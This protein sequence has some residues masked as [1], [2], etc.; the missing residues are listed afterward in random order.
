MPPVWRA[1]SQLKS[2]VRTLPMCRKPVGAG[3]N[4]TRTWVIVASLRAG[5]RRTQGWTANSSQRSGTP[6]SSCSP[7]ID[8]AQARTG[9]EVADRARHEHLARPGL[10]T[11]PEPRCA[12]RARRDRRRAA[13][14]HRCGCRP[15]PRTP[16]RAAASTIA[17]ARAHR[18]RRAVERR[19][20]AV[21]RR[22]DL[23]PAVAA[24]LGA[25]DRVVRVELAPARPRRPARPR[26][27]RVDDVGEE[28][29]RRAPGPR[30]RA[31]AR[32][33]TPRPRRAPRR[34]SPSTARGRHPARARAARPG[35]LDAR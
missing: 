28:H 25:H 17:I 24:E 27:G 11:R 32:S 10:R 3:E 31:G 2:A 29:R 1:C 26:A 5:P 30:T 6:F 18:L 9:D 16:R 23:P 20:E 35:C 22:V 19:D 8:E 7:R 12:R 33:G 13:R 15:G 4:R 21:A 34:R 14:T